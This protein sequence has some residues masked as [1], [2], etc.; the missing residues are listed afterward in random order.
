[1]NSVVKL[2]TAMS[3]DLVG[4][5]R[6]MIP[7]LRERIGETDR[8][9]RLPEATVDEL[10]SRGM[11]KL[12]GPKRRGG[13][14]LDMSTYMDVL[15]ELGRG[16]I[17]TAWAVSLINSSI[18][19]FAT[20]FPEKVQNEV[21]SSAN[22][23]IASVLHARKCIVKDVPGGKL[24]EHGV[25]G[26]NSG[27]YHVGWDL[28]GIPLTDEKGAVVDQGLALLPISDVTILGDWDT[29]GVRGSGSSS[30][31]VKNVFVPSER[32]CSMS[33]AVA[34]RV[35]VRHAPEDYHY[36]R[37]LDASVVLLSVTV[38]GGCDAALE[39]FTSKLPGRAIQHS[40]Y[41][42]S[43]QAAPI[44]LVL[45]EASAKIAAAKLLSRDILVRWDE[46]ARTGRKLEQ[47]E[48]VEMRRNAGLVATL[49]WEGVDLLAEASGAS[50]MTSKNMLNRIWRDVRTASLHAAHLPATM[51]EKYGRLVCGIKD[52]EG[53]G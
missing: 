13:F 48:L 52:A 51:F 25:W 29:I 31:E 42:D 3:L 43:S 15:G 5:A 34:G 24:I 12:L 21:F 10:E 11:F 37:S 16:D 50:M 30:V 19:L 45:G 32:I 28:L 1:M 20:M 9:A 6:A 8:L 22:P 23:R 27:V 2:E 46:A 4:S 40:H 14:Q 47:M 39:L 35:A 26:F 36:R 41:R 38:L 44:H 33:A 17:S 7:A 49:A 18:W 53:F